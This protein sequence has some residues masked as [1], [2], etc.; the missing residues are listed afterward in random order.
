[1]ANHSSAKKRIRRNAQRAVIN[2]IRMS[3]VRTFMRKVETAIVTGD[4][5]LARTALSEAIPE[6]MRSSNKGV[7][8]RNKVARKISRLSARIKMLG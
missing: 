1:M 4:H 6:M 8:H 7:M 2:R 3:R 5:T